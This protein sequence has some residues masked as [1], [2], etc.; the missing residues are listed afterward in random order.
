MSPELSSNWTNIRSSEISEAQLGITNKLE[1]AKKKK[2][3]KK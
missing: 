1:L 3:N 2:I